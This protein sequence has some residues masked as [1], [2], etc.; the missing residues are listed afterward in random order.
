MKTILAPID[1]SPVSSRV[2]DEAVRLAAP[3][4]GRVVLLHAA[5][6][7]QAGTDYAIDL[8]TLTELRTTVEQSA[9]QQLKEL[10]EELRQRG[11]AVEWRRLTGPAISEI[12][13]EATSLPAD[14]IVIGSHGHTAIYDLVIGSTASGVI[15]RAPC[16][17]IVVPPRHRAAE[18]LATTRPAAAAMA[19][20][21]G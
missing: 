1:F 13:A 6:V 10:A 5:R 3:V 17:V 12:I 11:V 19:A 2:L 4:G 8:K 16:P 21:E 9:D 20:T 14:Y 15:K 7:P 18:P